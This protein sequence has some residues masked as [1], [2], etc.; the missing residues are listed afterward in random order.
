MVHQ[1]RMNCQLY[2]AILKL[3]FAYHVQDRRIKSQFDER[4]ETKN[5]RSRKERYHVS[6]RIIEKQNHW[7]CASWWRI[8][9]AEL[10]NW[11]VHQRV[12]PTSEN[13]ITNEVDDLKKMEDPMNTRSEIC[14]WRVARCPVRWICT[15]TELP[16]TSEKHVQNQAGSYHIF[17][18]KITI[19]VYLG[20][21]T[22]ENIQDKMLTAKAKKHQLVRK[23][24]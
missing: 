18:V 21:H 11:D 19:H 14:T 20:L 7:M 9:P 12:K 22:W 23:W 3:W 17:Y 24:W 2:S 5:I 13:R 4:Q 8:T 15:E 16:T 10:W 1:I 6:Y